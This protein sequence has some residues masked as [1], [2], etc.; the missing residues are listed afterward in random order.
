MMAVTFSFQALEAFCNHTITNDLEGTFTLTRKN[1]GRAF[2]AIELER[3][4]S[5][6]EKLS[7]VLPEILGVKSPKGG[8][9][10]QDFVTLKRARDS[11]THL[12]SSDQYPDRNVDRETLFYQ[13]LNNDPTDFPKA[14]IRM[15]V[16]FAET[17]RLPRWLLKPVE[18]VGH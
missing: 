2:T 3:E 5:T 14:A 15:I 16:Y 6:E 11:T 18:F 12:K 8:K 1:E 4:V 13:F 17:K 9:V 7:S 10:W